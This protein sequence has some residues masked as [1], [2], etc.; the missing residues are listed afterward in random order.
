MEFQEQSE[1]ILILEACSQAENLDSEESKENTLPRL[2][3]STLNSV[4][5]TL[6]SKS[7][8]I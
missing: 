7:S 8:K 4:E 5:S 1:E 3:K 2:E 6:N